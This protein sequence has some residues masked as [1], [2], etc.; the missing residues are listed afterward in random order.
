M[1]SRSASRRYGI[2]MSGS[3]F[4]RKNPNAGSR[5]FPGYLYSLDSSQKGKGNNYIHAVRDKDGNLHSFLRAHPDQE[6]NC[7][8]DYNLGPKRLQPAA[9]LAHLSSVNSGLHRRPAFGVSFVASSVCA[10]VSLVR[11]L[12]PYLR[13]VLDK[14]DRSSLLASLVSMQDFLCRPKCFAIFESVHLSQ[15]R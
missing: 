11:L 9:I 8:L 10:L 15:L 13:R 6:G 7:V 2:G 3:G 4:G 1:D 5:H 12:P 14:D